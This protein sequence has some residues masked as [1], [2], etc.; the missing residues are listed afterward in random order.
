MSLKNKIVPM[1]IFS[2]SIHKKEWGI[3]NIKIHSFLQVVKDGQ[4]EE[5]KRQCLYINPTYVS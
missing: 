3:K 5:E 4:E 1:C 2:L